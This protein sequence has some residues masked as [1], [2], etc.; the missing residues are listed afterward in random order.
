[1]GEMI[2]ASDVRTGQVLDLRLAGRALVVDVDTRDG[3]TVINVVTIVPSNSLVTVDADPF[4]ELVREEE[5][6]W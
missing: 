5:G 6:L 2:R 3:E 1:M 4:A